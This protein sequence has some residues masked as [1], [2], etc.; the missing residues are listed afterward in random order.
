MPIKYILSILHL[1]KFNIWIL[2]MTYILLI[3]LDINTFSKSQ[4]WDLIQLILNA[5]LTLH[6]VISLI[7]FI[8]LSNLIISHSCQYLNSC[9][10]K[11]FPF[12]LFV[13]PL[14][15]LHIS[16]YKM[17][18]LSRSGVYFKSPILNIILAIVILNLHFLICSLLY[19]H[20]LI[21]YSLL[22]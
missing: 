6:E 5:K 19:A 14:I 2:E 1:S 18:I 12:L 8:F 10:L 17:Q 3:M 15:K 20:L 11:H 22:I 7:L 13:F 9:L 21:C 4:S 16:F